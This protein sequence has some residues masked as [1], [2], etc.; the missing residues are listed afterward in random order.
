[1]S[2]AAVEFLS[3][4]IAS[5]IAEIITIPADTIKVRMQ[6]PGNSGNAVSMARKIVSS[7]GLSALYQ[8]VDMAV[9]RQALY[10]SFRY[11]LY[12]LIEQLLRD[13]TV[14]KGAFAIKMMAGCSAGALAS[15][16]CN[17]TDLVKVRMQ[18]NTMKDMSIVQAFREISQKEGVVSLWTIGLGPTVLRAAVLAAVEMTSY[19]YFRP[20][21]E[22][23]FASRE[24]LILIPILTA[25]VASL[26]SSLASCPFD[27]ARSRV[28]N[29][30]KNKDGRGLDYNSSIDCI[31]K[32]VKK[33]GIFDLWSGWVAFYIRL[34]PNT[35]LTFYFL[36]L[37]RLLLSGGRR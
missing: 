23:I 12:P 25:M 18:G 35:I 30:K 24:T 20:I 29:Q 19:D 10:G 15:A 31:I 16:L 11:G 6:L 2:S 21:F 32:S 37:F 9:F 3:G 8:G 7:E 22:G 4:G 34:G 17:P 36:E 5:C 14:L 33:D 26:F 28:M 27:T 13:H 1:M